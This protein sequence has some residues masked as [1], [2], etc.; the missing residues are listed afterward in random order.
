MFK[1]LRNTFL[2]CSYFLSSLHKYCNIIKK[3][4]SPFY[5]THQP[6]SMRKFTNTTGNHSLCQFLELVTFYFVCLFSYVSVFFHTQHK[7]KQLEK[8]KIIQNGFIKFHLLLVGASVVVIIH[9]GIESKACRWCAC[10]FLPRTHT[11]VT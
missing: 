1:T 6:S 2:F 5:S 9:F 7:R 11:H 10:L 4:F 3:K 8:V